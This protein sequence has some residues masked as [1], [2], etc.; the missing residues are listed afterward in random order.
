MN[1]SGQLRKIDMWLIFKYKV[2]RLNE[3]FIIGQNPLEGVQ[4]D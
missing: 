2:Y 3:L 1:N 4:N